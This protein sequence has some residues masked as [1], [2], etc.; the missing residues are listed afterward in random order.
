MGEDRSFRPQLGVIKVESYSCLRLWCA[1]SRP[2]LTVFSPPRIGELHVLSKTGAGR[3]NR[4]PD[5]AVRYYKTQSR[6]RSP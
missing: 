6:T 1:S 5:G 2:P 3:G 4:V